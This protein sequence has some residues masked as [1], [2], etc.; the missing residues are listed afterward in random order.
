MNDTFKSVFLKQLSFTAPPC[1]NVGHEP[2]FDSHMRN[3]CVGYISEK[4]EASDS[5]QH[6]SFMTLAVTV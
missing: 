4:E 1:R 6:L 3:P 5:K 2:L